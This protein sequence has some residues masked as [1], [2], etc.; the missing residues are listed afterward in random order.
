MLSPS[1]SGGGGLSGG[2]GLC[3]FKMLVPT[4][5][6]GA[7]IGKNGSTIEEMRLLVGCQ[8]RISARNTVFPGTTDR[9]LIIGAAEH[10]LSECISMVMHQ[11]H[12][13]SSHAG[14][15]MTARLLVPN[16]AVSHL[17]GH[18]GARTK[19]LASTTECRVNISPRVEGLRERIVCLWGD[20]VKLVE[21]VALVVH[22]IQRDTHLA[23][24]AH[25]H[26]GPLPRPPDWAGREF[27]TSVD[28]CGHSLA[29]SESS[30]TKRENIDV[31]LSEFCDTRSPS[32]VMS[33]WS[34][35]SNHSSD[36]DGM[37]S[38]RPEDG[39]WP[40]PQEGEG[41]GPGLPLHRL[42]IEGSRSWVSLC[43]TRGGRDLDSRASV[44]SDTPR[45]HT[46]SIDGAAGASAADDACISER[47]PKDGVEDRIV[48]H[49]DSPPIL[50]HRR[51][52][53]RADGLADGECEDPTSSDPFDA[54]AITISS[55]ARRFAKTAQAGWLDLYE[56]LSH[57]SMRGP[58]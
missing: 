31:L 23:E 27:E 13:A 8:V 46:G 3:I 42:C 12:C 48:I 49:R 2:E 35:T 19:G 16:S 50:P 55:A 1:H 47:R 30:L 34:L 11:I 58:S 20:Y 36:H 53:H 4:R 57:C 33:T 18:G 41:R 15:R 26:Y 32:E 51:N 54:A 14:D 40:G 5:I 24:H 52:H 10:A 25:F 43:S 17:I 39:G 37:A 38:A 56:E 28:D 22:D 9:I 45:H 21:A 7:I 6:A 29:D 44:R